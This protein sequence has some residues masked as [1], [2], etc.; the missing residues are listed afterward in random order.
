MT[1]I[2]WLVG[3]GLLLHV[4][5]RTHVDI[6]AA[7][8]SKLSLLDGN[9]TLIFA[10]DSRMAFQADPMLAAQ[11][12]GLPEGRVVNIAYLAGE[13]LAFLAAAHARP[14]VFS[15]AHVVLSVTALI[16]NDG[17]ANAAIF[18]PDVAARMSVGEQMTMF[19]PMRVGTLIHY[20][21]EAFR[22]RFAADRKIAVYGPKPPD[23]GLERLPVQ[24]NYS[25]PNDISSHQHY[26]NW[27]IS[28][29]KAR[30]E[31]FA[32]CE[33]AIRTR[34]L[35]VVLPPWAPKYDR[36]KEP[37]WKAKDE[38]NAALIRDAGQQCGY[39]VHEIHLVPG[40]EL[41]HFADEQ[42]INVLGIP[43]Y[44]RYLMSRLKF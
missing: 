31:I 28:G 41:Q 25:W 9:P 2:T 39:E 10:G 33:L 38:A 27:N 14:E 11:V 13:P 17:I 34:K 36:S 18:P 32:L 21:R 43:I 20:I 12:M 7:L 42:H 8:A 15:G 1:T 5:N 3:L 40:L 19:L 30:H 29:V 44:T 4:A 26:R 22:S 23:Y 6:P 16:S 24:P 35:T 37:S